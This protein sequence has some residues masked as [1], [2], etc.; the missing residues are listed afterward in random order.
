MFADG[1]VEISHNFDGELFGQGASRDGTHTC[2]AQ[3]IGSRRSNPSNSQRASRIAPRSQRITA[4]MIAA[5]ASLG[6][7]GSW[8]SGLPVVRSA[9]A[10]D[11][12]VTRSR[13]ASSEDSSYADGVYTATGQYG[14]GPSSIAVT[15]TLVDDVITDARVTPHATNPISRVYQR[16]F[17]AAIP[18]AVAG[19]PIDQVRVGRR[20]GSSGTPDGFNA[21]IERIKEQARIARTISK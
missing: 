6:I 17:A 12:A 14:S 19:Q 10:L 18:A 20:A 11:S 7:T 2:R 13:G 3:P 4:V 5:F 8:T 1:R 21:A 9:L 15:V 16:R